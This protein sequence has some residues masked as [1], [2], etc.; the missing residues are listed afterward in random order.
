VL[1]QVQRVADF[2][3]WGPGLLLPAGLAQPAR[4]RLELAPHRPALPGQVR[5]PQ[6]LEQARQ[7]LRPEP[8]SQAVYSAQ[9]ARM[10]L[11]LAST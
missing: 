10:A 6:V 2:S 3:A 9:W 4:E 5:G 1:P 7:P 8:H 11:K